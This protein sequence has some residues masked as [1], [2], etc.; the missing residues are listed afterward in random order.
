LV[1]DKTLVRLKISFPPLF[2]LV[3]L[4][5]ISILF[6][7]ANIT[8]VAQ[9]F[10]LTFVFIGIFV[11]AFG[12]FFDFGANQY[13]QNMIVSKSKIRET[14]ITNINREQFIMNLIYVAIGITY[15]AI[16]IALT[17]LYRII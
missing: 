9:V 7:I 14:D 2:L 6:K 10:P 13:L 11:I 5:I 17:F 16:G 1:S 8:E 12:S 3:L 4:L 15:I